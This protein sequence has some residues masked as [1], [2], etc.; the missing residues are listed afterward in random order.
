MLLSVAYV[1]NIST[2]VFL[3]ICSWKKLAKSNKAEKIPL[4]PD[5]KESV[6]AIA[7][8]ILKATKLKEKAFNDQEKLLAAAKLEEAKALQKNVSPLTM[9]HWQLAALLTTRAYRFK[10]L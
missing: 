5:D 9:I 2:Y 4:K 6:E 1:S 10:L 3:A 8:Q 7:E